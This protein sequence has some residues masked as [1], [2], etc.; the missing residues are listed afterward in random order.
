MNTLQLSTKL[1]K[2]SELITL[3]SNKEKSN[4]SLLQLFDKFSTTKILSP[5][6]SIKPNGISSKSI[7]LG[8]LLMRLLTLTVRSLILSGQHKELRKD[9][10]FRLKNNESID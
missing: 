9:T 6:E 7:L 10:Y 5:L 4:E 3:L 2:I 1:G 8:L